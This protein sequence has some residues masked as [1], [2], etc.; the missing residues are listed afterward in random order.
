M[1]DSETRTRSAFKS[2]IWRIIGVIILAIITYA[3]TRNLFQTTLI[4]FLHH[5][6]FLFVYYIHERIWMKIK[7]FGNLTLRSLAKMFTYETLCG[8]IILGTITYLI[9]GSWKAMTAITLTY[10]GIKHVIYVFNEF[11][12]KKIKWGTI[13]KEKSLVKITNKPSFKYGAILIILMMMLIVLILMAL[14]IF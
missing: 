4:T 12:W 10:I 3:Y 8:N 1:R 7:S 11:I 9:T 6:I 5:G 14:I 2:F 13:E